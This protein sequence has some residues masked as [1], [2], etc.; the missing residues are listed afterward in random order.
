MV[1]SQRWTNVDHHAFLFVMV[2]EYVATLAHYQD[3]T[4]EEGGNQIE[5]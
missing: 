3:L 4:I 2:Y 1:D 5:F